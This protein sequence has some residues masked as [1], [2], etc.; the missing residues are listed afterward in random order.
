[1]AETLEREGKVRTKLSKWKIYKNS[2][3][4]INMVKKQTIRTEATIIKVCSEDTHNIFMG[5]AI[6]KQETI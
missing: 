6:N 4:F 2:V 1:M 5:M 3:K